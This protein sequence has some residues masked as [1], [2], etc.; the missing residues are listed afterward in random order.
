M[1]R[2]KDI[3]CLQHRLGHIMSFRVGNVIVSG[4]GL[5]FLEPKGAQLIISINQMDIV[6][7]YI[8]KMRWGMELPFNGGYYYVQEF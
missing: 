2:F 6:F 8:C 3:P 1:S 5:K 4:T 7:G